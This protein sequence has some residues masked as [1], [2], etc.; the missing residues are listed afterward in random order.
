MCGA[1]RKREMR[2]TSKDAENNAYGGELS[3]KACY[4]G[5][6]PEFA[7]MLV[8]Y[9]PLAQKRPTGPIGLSA[10]IYIPTPLVYC[11]RSTF[12]S[13]SLIPFGRLCISRRL[14]ALKIVYF[15]LILVKCSVIQAAVSSAAIGHRS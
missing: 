13:D 1:C 9:S 2:V 12:L 8:S 11:T 4:S 15:Q 3:F 7:L 6:A 10:V 14:L 5:S